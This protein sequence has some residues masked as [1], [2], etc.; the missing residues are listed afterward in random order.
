MVK[1]ERRVTPRFNLRIALT[2]HRVI[3][4]YEQEHA[5]AINISTRGVYFITNQEIQIGEAIE[6]SLEVPKRVTG[7]KAI[8]RRFVGRVAHVD[9][10]METGQVGVGV[11]FLYYEHD[12]IAPMLAGH[13][14]GD[15]SRGNAHR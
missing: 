2:F 12:L 7:S 8:N 15:D 9:S 5:N 6:I 1:S 13:G 4:P 11:Q 14:V 10:S 3:T